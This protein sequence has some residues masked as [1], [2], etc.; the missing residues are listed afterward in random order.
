MISHRLATTITGPVVHCTPGLVSE[1][2]LSDL[3]GRFRSAYWLVY[4]TESARLQPVPPRSPYKA[5]L[6]VRFPVFLFCY[7][8]PILSIT[9]NIELNLGRNPTF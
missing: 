3:S 6:V 5:T 7:F 1:T 4:G 8:G 9:L 2:R